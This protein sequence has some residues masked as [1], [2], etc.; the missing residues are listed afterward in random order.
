MADM[1]LAPLSAIL[2]IGSPVVGLGLWL[3]LLMTPHLAILAVLSLVLI[4]GLGR[5]LAKRGIA[6]LGVDFRM[7]GLLSALVTGWLVAPMGLHPGLEGLIIGAI[8]IVTLYLVYLGGVLT[9][10]GRLPLLVWPYCVVAGMLLTLFPQAASVS[11]AYFSWP[12]MAPAGLTGLPSGLLSSLGVF[13]LSPS[14]LSG[15]V[16]ALLVIAWSPIMFL[17]GICGWLAGAVFSMGLA[18]LG[19]PVDWVPTSCNGFLAGMALGAVFLRPGWSGLLMAIF[20]GVLASLLA[21]FLQIQSGYSGISYLPLPFMLTLYS[22]LMARRLAGGTRVGPFPPAAGRTPEQACITADWLHARWGDRD[23]AL[24]VLPVQGSV[25]ITQGTDGALTHTGAWRHAVDLQRPRVGIGT[26][27]EFRPSIWGES[28]FA[29]VQ[30]SVVAVCNSV[31]DNPLGQINYGENW[32]NH[33]ILRSGA[34]DHVALC[35]LMAGSVLVQPGQSVGYATPLGRI[36][37]SGRSSV[38]HLHLQAQAEAAIGAPTRPFRLANYLELDPENGQCRRWIASGLPPEG[39]VLAPALSN[40]AMH[41]LLTGMLPGRG[42][43][44]TTSGGGDAAPDPDPKAGQGGHLHIRAGL[45]ENGLFRLESPSGEGLEAEF[46]QDALRIVAVDARPD[47]FIA[48]LAIAMSTLPYAAF[49]GLAWQDA[50]FIPR[51]RRGWS[52]RE[53]AA[54]FLGTPLTR[55]ALSCAAAEYPETAG[56]VI[57]AQVQN[58]ATAG[59][60]RLGLTLM[61]Q[62][63]PVRLSVEQGERRT[64]RELV[65]FEVH[66]R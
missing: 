11:A 50:L 32:G 66:A 24:L 27:G 2:M 15:G 55:V 56:F 16:V 19:A 45:T 18:M 20:A 41:D 1:L 33:V 14:V 37:N 29:P 36:G 46:D 26:P 34:G 7:N 54:P 31:P 22:G 17:S 58:P 44:I 49:P 5:L 42:L 9:R 23:A 51:T 28:V 25:E 52:L 59:P 63:G 65:S 38:P 61:P 64:V 3:V 43:W 30:G 40:P 35:H 57:N 39:S 62:R 47:S 48:S 21:A 4:E 53:R 8:V 60:L 6:T 10:G 12:V 13:F